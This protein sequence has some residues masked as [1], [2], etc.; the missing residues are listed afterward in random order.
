MMAHLTRFAVLAFVVIWGS[1][2]SFGD[3]DIGEEDYYESR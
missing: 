3:K 2:V 1:R